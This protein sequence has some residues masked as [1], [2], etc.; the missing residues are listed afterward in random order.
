MEN[1]EAE[2]ARATDPV[3]GHLLGAVAMVVDNKGD[4]LY[5]KASGSQVL[6]DGS[7][8]LNE[9]CTLSLFSAG[10]FFTNVAALQLVDRGLIGLDSAIK[11]HIPEIERC[12]VVKRTEDGQVRVRSPSRDIILPRPFDQHQRH[13]YG[14]A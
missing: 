13:R 14:R 10:R 9:D 2:L 12:M 7:P 8:M 3:D 6:D 4:F 1:F 5:R 11:T